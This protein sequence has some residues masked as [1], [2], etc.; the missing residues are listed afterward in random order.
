MGV[1]VSVKAINVYGK[2]MCQ[3]GNSRGSDDFQEMVCVLDV[4]GVMGGE[5]A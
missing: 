1:D 2:E 3:I 5:G 4:A